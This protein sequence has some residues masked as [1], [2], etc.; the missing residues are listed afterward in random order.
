MKLLSFAVAV[1]MVFQPHPANCASAAS[2][3]SASSPR[4]TLS[5]P[6]VQSRVSVQSTDAP[7]ILEDTLPVR[8]GATSGIMDRLV[9]GFYFAL[10]YALNVYYNSTSAI[11]LVELADRHVVSLLHL[12]VFGSCSPWF[13]N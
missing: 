6:S 4:R 10:W 7:A 11:K 1:L 5:V 9:V 3:V 2:R 13:S 8:G 12:F